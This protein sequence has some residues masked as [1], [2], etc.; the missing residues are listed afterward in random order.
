MSASPRKKILFTVTN[1]LNHDQRMIR[2]C[3]TLQEAGYEVTLIG[4]KLKKSKPLNKQNFNQ[5]RMNL[6]FESGKLFY[7]HYNISLLWKLLWMPCDAICSIDL[8]SAV[9]GILV[10]KLRGKGHFFDAHEMFP[11]VPEVQRRKGI[12]R[13]WLGIEKWVFKN[14][15]V[16]YTVGT[17]LANHFH[18]TYHKSVEVVR[19]MPLKQEQIRLPFSHHL[20]AALENKPYLLYQG[21]L[22][23]GRGLEPLLHA[24]QQ[25]SIPLVIAGEGDLSIS[26]RQLAATLQLHHV[27]FV[28]QIPPADLPAITSHAWLGINVS[29]NVGLSYYLSLNNKFFDY[30][31][32]G[33][34][35]I[36]NRFPEYE[37]L[38]QIHQTGW[39]CDANSE[40][41]AHTILQI[42]QQPENYQRVKSQCL[43]AAQ[44]WNWENE[45]QHLIQLYNNYFS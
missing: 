37:Q 29:D 16:A 14:T 6:W 1:D 26:L 15:Q 35:S 24:M 4:R 9:P 33:L 10:A 7:L 17:A 18:K 8:D 30:I 22:N 32:S 36:I 21:A 12:Q 23:E 13:I 3:G 11:Y 40:E 28:G 25:I 27:H 43:Q 19:N 39:L 44:T 2:I 38:L 41:I 42:Q 20:P 34:P 31:Q 45:K 5:L